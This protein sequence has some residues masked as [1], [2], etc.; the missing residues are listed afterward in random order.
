[1]FAMIAAFTAAKWKWCVRAVQEARSNLETYD[2]YCASFYK[3]K[4]HI[5]TPGMGLLSALHIG[6]ELKR[7]KNWE[8]AKVQLRHFRP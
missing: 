2:Q 4:Q 7:L 8:P 6:E 1:M 5:W 3:H